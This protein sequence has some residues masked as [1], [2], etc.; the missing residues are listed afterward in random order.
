VFEL[1]VW[2]LYWGYRGIIS[3]DVSGRLAVAHTQTSQQTQTISFYTSVWDWARTLKNLLE[4][5]KDNSCRRVWPFVHISLWDLEKNSNFSKKTKKKTKSIFFD[6]VFFLKFFQIFFFRALPVFELGVWK[7]Y[8]EYRGIISLD[9]SGRLAVA[10]TQTSQQTQTLS[11]Y[12]SVWDWARALKNLLG[13]HKDDSCRRVWPFVHISHRDLE[14]NSNFSKKPKKK[15]KSIFFDLV[16]FLKFFQKKF[17]SQNLF[18]RAL[19]VFELGVW[20][21]YW[22]YK[23]I[24]SLDMS[25]C[26]AISHTGTSQQTQTISFYTSVWDW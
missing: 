7:L 5:H 1:G 26:L 15:T 22:E 13:A 17:L 18:F 6:L 9:M 25:G 12:T 4:A 14:K 10:H 21:L 24:I 2:K 11:F 3:L 23:G 20:K 8:W 16:F 19:H